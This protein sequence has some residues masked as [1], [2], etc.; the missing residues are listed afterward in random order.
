MVT[1]NLPKACKMEFSA[2]EKLM[3]CELMG[4]VFLVE[5]ERAHI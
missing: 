4:D 2:A 3:Q 5:A 1:L